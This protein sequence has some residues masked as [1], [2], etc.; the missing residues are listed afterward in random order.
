MFPIISEDSYSEMSISWH[1]R[2]DGKDLSNY[3]TER[4]KVLAA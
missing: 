4:L 2:Q 3:F 1:K